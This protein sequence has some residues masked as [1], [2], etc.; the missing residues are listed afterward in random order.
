MPEHRAPN[1]A[2]RTDTAAP[3]KREDIAAL[4]WAVADR[5]VDKH[6]L[7]QLSAV[8]ARSETV[9]LDLLDEREGDL[10]A[11]RRL[12][13]SERRQAQADIRADLDAL[14][15][16]YRSFVGADPELI[17]PTPPATNGD[18]SRRTGQASE[19][20]AG[21]AKSAVPPEPAALQLSWEAPNVVAWVA[22]ARGEPAPLDAVLEHLIAA[23]SPED[24]WLPHPPV[25]LPNGQKADAVAADI[26]DVLGWLVALD[27]PVAS[28]PTVDV[29]AAVS[30][31]D[32]L[33][34]A[35]DV[36]PANLDPNAASDASRNGFADHNVDERNDPLIGQSAAWLRLAAMTALGVVAQGRFVPLLRR[37]RRRKKKGQADTAEFAVAWQ[38]AS[39]DAAALTHLADTL[40]GAVA[41]TTNGTSNG[42]TN[43]TKNGA[44]SKTANGKPAGA[45]GS[46][47]GASRKGGRANKPAEASLAP[48]D[49]AAVVDSVLTCVVNALVADVAARLGWPDTAPDART[50]AELGEAFLSR[51]D[52]ATFTGSSGRGIEVVRRIETWAKPVLSPLRHPLTVKLSDP[53]DAGAWQLEVLS[54]SPQETEPVEVA[55]VS[56]TSARR[57]DVKAQLTRLERVLP[58]LM[59]PGGRRRGEV[60]LTTP[61]AWE[62]MAHTGP[63]LAAAGFDVDT[64]AM[65]RDRPPPALR[66]TA[67][68]PADESKLGV[69]QLTA[70]S[71]T[72]MFGD[73]E[74]TMEELNQLAAQ[75]RPL[76][77]SRGR[78]V[79]VDHA[80]VNEA[81]AALAKRADQTQMTGAQILRQTL[82]LEGAAL[83]GGVSIA[84]SG[85]AVDLLRASENVGA[86]VSSTPAGFFGSLRTYQAEAL[87]WLDFLDEASLGGCLALDMGLGKTPI[88]LAMVGKATET[89]PTLVIAPPAVVGNWAAEA[90]R[91]TPALNVLVHHGASRA[92]RAQLAR[93]VERANLVIT[94]Y[95]T[96]VR[97]I[98]A[99]RKLT[100]E[101]VVVDEAQVIKNHNSHTAKTLRKLEARTKV[102]LTGT[103]I[104]NGL[105]DLWAIMDFTNPGLVGERAPF[106]AQLAE[107]GDA[108][109][110]ADKA[111][112]KLNG[113]LVFR[114]T[115]A[116]PA[117]AAE[118]PDRIDEVA[119]CAMTPE[120]IAL[121]AAVQ[122]ELVAEMAPSEQNTTKRKGAVLAAI[123]A[124]KQICNH[125]LNF[126]PDD[127][128]VEM[129]G[130]SGKLARLNELLEVVFAAQERVLIFTHFATWGE[131]LADYLTERYGLGIDCYHGG[132]SR[133]VRDE[134]VERFSDT[135]GAGALVLSLKAGGTGLNLTAASHVVLY[136]RWWNPAVE[137][138][139]RDRAWRIGQTK[140]VVCHRLVCTGTVD[141]R[142][143][144]VVAGKRMIADMALPKSSS[145][146]DLT[147]EQLRA[148]L[149]ID[150]SLLVTEAGVTDEGVIDVAEL[151]Q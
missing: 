54:V 100:W 125:P 83:E 139:A 4:V 84:G 59:R 56:G 13:G 25:S 131:R 89:A 72:A 37:T 91:F 107:E 1:G 40:P 116:E 92:S 74:L 70:V 71:W 113:V 58:A 36:D 23:G 29:A 96:A 146:G 112:T 123:T 106:V 80:D 118:L 120:Q 108:T 141:E 24:P 30:A 17:R 121:Y 103:P 75:A 133:G 62:L 7:G 34:R 19:T 145:L 15:A 16:T 22:G 134:M 127:P 142:V 9:I 79:A 20:P 49:P 102:A 18:A 132:L 136:D 28:G 67:A 101:R 137:D 68:V 51:L 129:D 65:Q 31:I 151:A 122:E 88:M 99:L 148:A 26:S 69:N 126:R 33:E 111:L 78:W 52:G 32:E 128:N 43:G 117:I 144:E 149:G 21:A 64:P 57:A 87:A 140:T 27:A 44:A 76:V 130:R 97:D 93:D 115:K 41:V 95:G 6:E 47:Q 124:L 73:V 3:T 60:M 55:L 135:K 5:R 39:V 11:T 46:Q 48:A 85:W 14:R 50:G 45:K 35:K 90:A 98:E 66:L 114:R 104:E 94:T 105:R 119:Q 8:R 110:A 150:E 82:G 2:T 147:A 53:D 42:I 38:P 12:R 143:E 77:R 138:Q 81:R 10:A 63:A 86:E 109:A 61:E